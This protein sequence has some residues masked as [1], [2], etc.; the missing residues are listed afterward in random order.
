MPGRSKSTV[1]EAAA[2]KPAPTTAAS[3]TSAGGVTNGTNREALLQVLLLLHNPVK[4]TWDPFQKNLWIPFGPLQ[5]IIA[6]GRDVNVPPEELIGQD[7]QHWVMSLLLL[8]PKFCTNCRKLCDS[9]RQRYTLLFGPT[10]PDRP[11]GAEEDC[12]ILVH[13]APH[14]D[15]DRCRSVATRSIKAIPDVQVARVNQERE[16]Q[17]Q[18]G[19]TGTREV[20]VYVNVFRPANGEAG[21]TRVL[22]IVSKKPEIPNVAFFPFDKPVDELRLR[23]WAR[24]PVMHV[25]R[26]H[27]KAK[28]AQCCACMAAASSF[29]SNLKV[30]TLNLTFVL[31]FI[32]NVAFHCEIT[33]CRAYAKR[34]VHGTS[35]TICDHC[36]RDSKSEKKEN[37]RCSRCKIAVYCSDKCSHDAWKEHK[38]FCAAKVKVQNQESGSSASAQVEGSVEPSAS[39]AEA[40]EASLRASCANCGAGAPLGGKLSSCGNCQRVSYCNKECQRADWKNHKGACKKV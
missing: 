34:L 6:Q 15:N 31:G 12:C 22:E 29:Q 26:E 40:V 32:A 1:S 4:D 19:A 7:A 8:R 16:V 13:A 2:A 3:A 30:T 5:E 33:A 27:L 35:R 20:Q 39:S 36:G 17:H 23:N 9:A 25:V 24:E 28:E 18:A 21:P 10:F 37:Q 14:C 11:A 38:E